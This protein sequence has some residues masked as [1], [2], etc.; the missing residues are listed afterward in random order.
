M[1]LIFIYTNKRQFGLDETLEDH[2]DDDE[3]YHNNA[4]ANENDG[5]L[6][7]KMSNKSAPNQSLDFPA[8]DHNML[9]EGKAVDL[10]LDPGQ[11]SPA[12]NDNHRAEEESGG[13]SPATSVD[14]KSTLGHS[15]GKPPKPKKQ[16]EREKDKHGTPEHEIEVA[17]YPAVKRS[18]E[19]SSLKLEKQSPTTTPPPGENIAGLPGCSILHF[20]LTQDF[21]MSVVAK[22][23]LQ[24]TPVALPVGW[25][26]GSTF[27]N[28]TAP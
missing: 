22:P 10:A 27:I 14:N 8:V 5:Q 20:N 19:R 16:S 13:P 2:E 7:D 4:N 15:H 9:K 12:D 18:A 25:S 17:R 1:V 3:H 24:C 21:S 11:H 23:P 26:P 6:E 28:L